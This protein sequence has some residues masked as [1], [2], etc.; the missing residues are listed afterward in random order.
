AVYGCMS[1]DGP[2]GHRVRGPACECL[3]TLNQQL[4]TRIDIFRNPHLSPSRHQVI[5]PT[6]SVVLSLSTDMTG[7]SSTSSSHSLLNHNG[8]DVRPSGDGKDRSQ[9]SCALSHAI[10]S[11]TIHEADDGDEFILLGAHQMT[12]T[13][14]CCC[15]LQCAWPLLVAGRPQ[16]Q[17]LSLALVEATLDLLAQCT[18]ASVLWINMNEDD[19][20]QQVTDVIIM[21]T[22]EIIKMLSDIQESLRCR[23]FEPENKYQLMCFRNLALVLS[24]MLVDFVSVEEA[25]KILDDESFDGLQNLLLNSW[26]SLECSSLHQQLLGHLMS[27]KPTAGQ[28]IESMLHAAKLLRTTATFMSTSST[29]QQDFIMLAEQCIDISLVHQSPVFIEKLVRGLAKQGAHGQMSQEYIEKAENLLL[30]IFSFP[31]ATFRLLSHK[32]VLHLV[33]ESIGVSC[34]SDVS[35][36]RSIRILVLLSPSIIKQLLYGNMMDCTK[37]V[38]E[39]SRNILLSLMRGKALMRGEVWQAAAKCWKGCLNHIV[40]LANT[41]THIGRAVLALPRDIFTSEPDYKKLVLMFHLQCLYIKDG[42][43]RRA[44]FQEVVHYLLPGAGVYHPD[45]YTIDLDTQYNIFLTQ[46][47]IIMT[48]ILPPIA[49]ESGRLLQVLE[50]IVGSGSNIDREVQ[51]A[52]WSQLAFILQDPR[53]HATMLHHCSLEYLITSLSDMLKVDISMGVTLEFIPGIIEVLRQLAIYSTDVRITLANDLE[54]LLCILRSS[55][56]H[57]SNEH[58][59]SSSSCLMFFLLFNDVMKTTQKTNNKDEINNKNVYWLVPEL[60]RDKVHL[61]FHCDA[62]K[63]P[64]HFQISTD[65]RIV[66]NLVHQDNQKARYAMEF[67]QC[68]WLEAQVSGGLDGLTSSEWEP[69]EFSQVLN[70]PTEGENILRSFITTNLIKDIIYA[71]ENGTSH[72]EVK[73]NVNMLKCSYLQLPLL[74]KLRSRHFFPDLWSQ[75]MKRFVTSQP[76]STSDEQLLC[77]VI[78]SIDTLL[79]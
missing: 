7:G 27:A 3:I 45:P 25:S 51:R 44:A 35:K 18:L 29:K 33:E 21:M 19:Q 67:L 55:L 68:V 36:S 57:S 59:R 8:A 28:Q 34:A 47:P 74:P 17:G 9:S 4:K 38:V 77:H 76:N 22:K 63:W 65:M 10:S 6:S 16:L 70:L 40:C 46:Q 79:Q 11:S 62:Y 32:S 52:A 41:Q 42:T 72:V 20:H 49:I 71:V 54:V 53:L 31:D 13:T 61:P 26:F 5:T 48:K 60:L 64:E 56:I 69:V 15:V 58:F 66:L 43:T 12:V 30:D 2:S 75:A 50:L 78:D 39:T 37:E 23:K 14:H 1:E 24:R 73:K